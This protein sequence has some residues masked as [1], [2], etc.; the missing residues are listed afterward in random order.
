M[1]PTITPPA[2]PVQHTAALQR[3]VLG[4]PVEGVDRTRVAF[5]GAQPGI[6]PARPFAAGQLHTGT[7]KRPLRHGSLHGGWPPC[8]ISERLARRLPHCTHRDRQARTTSN[9][10]A[11]GLGRQPLRNHS[12]HET[13]QKTALLATEN[14]LEL[15]TLGRTGTVVNVETC[16]PIAPK[17]VP[18]PVRRKD[19]CG[20]PDLNA[21]DLSLCDI[22]DESSRAPP[23]VWLRRW[24]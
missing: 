24:A 21:I 23:L 12:T 9:R 4:T 7:L 17:E 10:D 11:H 14:R 1:A 20:A 19:H 6:R 2:G 3:G 8:L 5:P 22:I 15:P 16:C 18:G 13:F